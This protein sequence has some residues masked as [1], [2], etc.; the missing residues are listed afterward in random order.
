MPARSTT[1]ARPGSRS[2]L[3]LHSFR[4]TGRLV[5]P[6]A[7]ALATGTVAPAKSLGWNA[8]VLADELAH[9]GKLPSLPSV[10][11][12]LKFSDFFSL[13]AGPRGLE[14]TERIRALDGKRVRILGFMVEQGD[15]SPGVAIIAPFQQTTHEDEYGLCDDL[16]PATLFAIVSKYRESPVPFTPGP[17]LL[18]GVLE[19]GQ[20]T[21]A[22]GRVS[23]VR[24]ILD[25]ESPALPAAAAALR[26]TAAT[27]SH[28]R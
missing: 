10:A 2:R 15:P 14:F 4:R 5:L 20:R 3:P 6:L 8:D 28:V 27:H 18:T 1:A 24:L 23:H 16:P 22:D 21:E 11:S 17:L 12:E 7:F 9:V 26:P 13:P 25:P 19:L